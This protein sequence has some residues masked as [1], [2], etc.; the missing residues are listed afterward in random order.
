MRF[1]PRGLRRRVTKRTVIVKI[2]VDERDDA[3][4]HLTLRGSHGPGGPDGP[5]AKNYAMRRAEA[6][7]PAGFIPTAAWYRPD[8]ARAH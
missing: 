4:R 8:L 1:Q 6:L 2:G 5:I 7:A 3:L